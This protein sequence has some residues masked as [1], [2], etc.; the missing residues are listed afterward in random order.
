MK[1]VLDGSE[2]ITP[3]VYHTV[4]HGLQRLLL[5]FSLAKNESQAVMQL[6]I[7]R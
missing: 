3:S 5:S 6:A 7:Q 2:A 4:L 1:L